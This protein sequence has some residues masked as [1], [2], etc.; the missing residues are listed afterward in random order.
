M[1]HSQPQGFLAV[2]P[3]GK[4]PGVLVLHAWWGLNDTI[5][6][7]CTQLAES[8]FVVF[9]PDLYHG[10]VADTISD[11]EKLG[12]A[13]DEN[14][15][16]AKA[17]IAE[18]ARFLNERVGQT[19]RG[20]AVIAFSLG[21]YYALD[22]AAAD[23]EHIRSVVLYYGAGD[24]DYSSSRADYLGHFAEQDQFEPQSTIDALE[25]SLKRAGRPVTFYRYSGTGHWFC[26]PDRQDAFNPEAASLAW[27]RT[28]AFLER[29]IAE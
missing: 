17:E 21:V 4:G 18:A 28:L 7:F 3:A 9:A 10:K 22:L 25:E 11:A 16:Q 15:L 5:K 2:P 29:P 23:P 20:L 6:A 1:T 24:G 26:E 27:E 14:Y 8:G 19:E 13:L 12:S